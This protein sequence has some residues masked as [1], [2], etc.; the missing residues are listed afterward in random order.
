MRFS[1]TTMATFVALSL[2][3]KLLSFHKIW[4]WIAWQLSTWQQLLCLRLPWQ[5]NKRTRMPPVLLETVCWVLLPKKKIQYKWMW[6]QTMISWKKSNT[7]STRALAFASF[8]MRMNKHYKETIVDIL[9]IRNT[10]GNCTA[11]KFTVLGNTW[12]RMMAYL[13]QQARHMNCQRV[14]FLQSMADRLQ[15]WPITITLTTG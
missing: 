10:T 1:K 3:Y 14:P 6:V 5:W 15:G 7:I 8:M 11:V 13:R 2:E 4:N 9:I 12:P